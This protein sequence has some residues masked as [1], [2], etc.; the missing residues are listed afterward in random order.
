MR[1]QP[2]TKKR[3][4]VDSD[5]SDASER[6]RYEV[7]GF[8]DE[9]VRDGKR[10]LLVRWVGYALPTWEPVDNIDECDRLLREYDEDVDPGFREHNADVDPEFNESTSDSDPG[11]AEE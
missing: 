2:P 6:Q 10:F 3:V 4:I 1:G 9:Q 7:S 5:D 8:L 11:F